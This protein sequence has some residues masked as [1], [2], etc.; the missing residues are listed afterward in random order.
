MAAV[1][2]H[3]C[4]QCNTI[5]YVIPHAAQKRTEPSELCSACLLAQWEEAERDAR[6][7]YGQDNPPKCIDCQTELPRPGP[8]GGRP[9]Q[10]CE[11]CKQDRVTSKP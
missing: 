6:R 5:F 10:R 3:I 11:S 7:V 9:K 8:Q 4:P 1:P 2:Q